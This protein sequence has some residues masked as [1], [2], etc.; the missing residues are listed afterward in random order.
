MSPQCLTL[1]S[2]FW[3][4]G[5]KGPCQKKKGNKKVINSENAPLKP[6]CCDVCKAWAALFS[7]PAW[8]SQL[9]VTEHRDPRLSAPIC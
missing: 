9:I 7:Q 2:P 4:G 3:P 8:R 1:T 5:P 6:S